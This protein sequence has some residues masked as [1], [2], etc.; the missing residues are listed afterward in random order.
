MMFKYTKYGYKGFSIFVDRSTTMALR[1]EKFAIWQRERE[2]KAWQKK[3]EKIEEEN[4]KKLMAGAS[5]DELEKIPPRPEV[6]HDP[7]LSYSWD[8]NFGIG[9]SC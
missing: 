9:L 6:P 2:Q 1:R 7:R 8:N 5:P 4:T 3:K